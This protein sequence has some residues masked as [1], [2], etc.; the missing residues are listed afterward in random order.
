MLAS[1]GLRSFG[2]TMKRAWLVALVLA[3]AI[4]TPAWAQQHIV[5]ATFV[6]SALARGAILWD[7]RD[8]GAFA[9]GHI[10]GAV[11]IGVPADELRDGNT[12]DYLPIPQLEKILGA[13][14]LDP[15]REV[16]VYAQRGASGAY[17]AQFTLRYFGAQT[18]Y[19]YHDGID[20][21][22]AAGERVATE[23]T[24]P[25]SVVLKLARVGGL[26]IDTK[27]VIAAVRDPNVQ[28]V[29]VRTPKEFRGEDIR[30]IRGGHIP[31]ALNIPYEQN[32]LDPD[33]I[34][35]MRRGQLKDSTGMSLKPRDELRKLYAALDPN[36]ETIVYCQ[37]GNRA[38]ETVTVLAD[39]GFKNVKLY[40]SSW[41][42]YAAALTAPAEDEVFVNVGALNSQIRSLESR[43]N[44]LEA[45][46]QQKR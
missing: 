44:A 1:Y 43:I 13:A 11:N 6:K 29:D 39:L 31:S 28:F 12:E 37:S 40:D 34:G 9:K 3:L 35:K 21:W 2:D 8:E 25:K 26:T 41:L 45:A 17:F 22:R 46:L 10:P 4:A 14:G 32:W 42:G 15:Q 5:D 30:A 19:V 20:G 18:A 38:A 7:A 36:K 23:P 24:P 33:A 27:D 16:V